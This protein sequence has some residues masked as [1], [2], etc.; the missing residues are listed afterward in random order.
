MAFEDCGK[1]EEAIDCFERIVDLK[2]KEFRSKRRKIDDK[3][4]IKI[5][6]RNIKN[7]K[8]EERILSGRFVKVILN[9][10]N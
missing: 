5:E 2:L 6:N 10:K 1:Y 3:W 4:I 9:L 7:Q 8:G